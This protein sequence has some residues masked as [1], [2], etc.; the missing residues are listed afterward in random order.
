MY[1]LRAHT[2]HP[3]FSHIYPNVGL[4]FYPSHLVLYLNVPKY[5]HTQ[6]NQ[7]G[8]GNLKTVVMEI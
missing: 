1:V 6:Q 7:F 8:H 3:S 2:L 5:I 4:P